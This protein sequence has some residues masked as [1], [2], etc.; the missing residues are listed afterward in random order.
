VCREIVSQLDAAG[1]SLLGLLLESNL[2]EGRQ[3]WTPGTPLRHGISITDACIG[4]DDTAALLGEIAEAVRR[5][6]QAA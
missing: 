3:D 5:R 4:W 1:S 2:N 6:T